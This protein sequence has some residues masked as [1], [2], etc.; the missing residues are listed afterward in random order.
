MSIQHIK[1]YFRTRM[2]A[3]GYRKE[4][5][6][7]FD[8]EEVPSTIIDETFHILLGDLTGI[9]ITQNH[10][11]IEVPVGL[12]MFFKG[13]RS[14]EDGRLRAME[15]MEDIIKECCTAVN[16]VTQASDG[17]KNVEFATGVAVPMDESQDNITLLQMEFVVLYT[18]DF[19]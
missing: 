16:R 10:Q 13:Y 2:S 19:E 9:S 3:L 6:E 18:L 1:P 4:H 14:E 17:I 11:V 5:P 12:Q 7:A 8:V 15:A